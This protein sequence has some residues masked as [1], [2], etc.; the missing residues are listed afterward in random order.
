[1]KN[2]LKCPKCS[3]TDLIFIPGPTDGGVFDNSVR[4]GLTVFS[5]VPVN[6]YVCGECGYSEEW[7]NLEDIPK[8]QKKYR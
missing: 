7:V 4:T 5:A 6:R 8:L 3:S 2:T 1:M